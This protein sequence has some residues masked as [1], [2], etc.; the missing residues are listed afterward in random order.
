MSSNNELLLISVAENVQFLSLNAVQEAGIPGKLIL[1]P[2]SLRG[3]ALYLAT[4]PTFSRWV[5]PKP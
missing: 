1:A 5:F 3:S 4:L 2:S